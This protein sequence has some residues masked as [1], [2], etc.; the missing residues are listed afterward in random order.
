MFS[1]KTTVATTTI[2]T[3]KTKRLFAG[4]KKICIIIFVG[5]LIYVL[6]IAGA[7]TTFWAYNNYKN[8]QKKN[9][10]ASDEWA[11][12]EYSEM[13]EAQ[14]SAKLYKE[15]GK[16]PVDILDNRPDKELLPTFASAY[17]AAQAMFFL[18]KYDKAL[19]V[20]AFADTYASKNKTYSFYLDYSGAAQ[21][22]E[23]KDVFK[24]Q[25]EVTK[26]AISKDKSLDAAAKQN[27]IDDIDA[28]LQFIEASGN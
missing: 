19:E 6:L 11:P 18:G 10:V 7:A 2:K 1:K 21:A 15:T 13:N 16:S 27:F 26:M 25:I 22:A 28:K 23:N 24:K 8:E 3:N 20:Y 14:I 4:D 9:S 17:S 5:V 12:T